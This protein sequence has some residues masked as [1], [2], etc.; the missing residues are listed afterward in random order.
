MTRCCSSFLCCSLDD[1]I[2]EGKRQCPVEKT[3]PPRCC[4]HVCSPRTR[5][6]EWLLLI[7]Q[8]VWLEAG[9][10]NRLGTLFSPPRLSYR[11]VLLLTPV[12]CH[13]RGPQI[14]CR[15]VPLSPLHT[16]SFSLSLL[17]SLSLSLRGLLTHTV[18]CS[19]RTRYCR[20][21]AR[22]ERRDDLSFST[23]CISRRTVLSWLRGAPR[24]LRSPPRVGEPR[25][26]S[27]DLNKIYLHP[28]TRLVNARKNKLFNF[29]SPRC[30]LTLN[31]IPKLLHISHKTN[32]GVTKGR[33][34]GALL[35]QC[36]TC[37]SVF[38]LAWLC[39]H[40]GA[41]VWTLFQLPFAER[42]RQTSLPFSSCFISLPRPTNG[43]REIQKNTNKTLPRH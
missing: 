37:S 14:S 10:P 30:I 24:P 25:F 17:V 41:G 34:S 43:C 16:N 21:A 18:V 40:H 15:L 6:W 39:G 20:Y 29:W 36:H 35:W 38:D 9:R 13:L 28:T 22:S 11:R 12:L 8:P 2:G 33:I 4:Q 32:R 31:P 1:L 23:A 42:S 27:V 5:P 7:P 3:I 26:N 19:H